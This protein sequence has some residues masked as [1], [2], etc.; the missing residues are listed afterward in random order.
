MCHSFA[1]RID[2][3]G[4]MTQATEKQ[5]FNAAMMAQSAQEE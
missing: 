4:M 5:R 2:N 1:C 3:D